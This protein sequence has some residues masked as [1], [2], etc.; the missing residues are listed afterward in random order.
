MVLRLIKF[1][2]YF[3]FCLGQYQIYLFWKFIGFIILEKLNSYEP[4]NINYVRSCVKSGDYC[5][6]AGA[7]M[8]IYTSIFQSI[9]GDT[10]MIYTFEVNP[11]LCTW[12]KRRF[13]NYINIRVYEFGLGDKSE[14]CNLIIPKIFG[15]IPEPALGQ[16]TYT[17]EHQKNVT[18]KRLDEIAKDW[19]RLNF[20]KADLE[21]NELPFLHGA[22]ETI[23]R[24]KP[25]IL[26]E[27]SKMEKQI[28]KYL[29]FARENSYELK[30]IKN[31][32]IDNQDFS[33][34]YFILCPVH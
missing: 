19:K 12:L 16:I 7:H 6:D 28:S 5:L 32:K 30:T 15:V 31:N 10:G 8:G 21:G 26:F 11:D 2:F 24:L 3:T 13:V 23:R 27:E 29:E 25:I 18:I 4:E 14:E 33:S 22:K 17:P 9:V 20:I 1:F 34:N